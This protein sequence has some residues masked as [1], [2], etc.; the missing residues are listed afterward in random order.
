MKMLLS[1]TLI[2]A[3]FF[4]QIAC[5]S[6]PREKP[7]TEYSDEELV[8]YYKNAPVGKPKDPGYD[9]SNLPS[10]TARVIVM[11]PVWVALLFTSESA[12]QSDQAQKKNPGI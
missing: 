12:V 3:V 2:I 10:D 7:L 1:L 8:Y 6:K 5:H 11:L 4:G 9:W